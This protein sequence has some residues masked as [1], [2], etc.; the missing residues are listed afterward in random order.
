MTTVADLEA[1]L[2]LQARDTDLD[3][4]RHRRA[5]LPELA[6]LSTIDGQVAELD[7]RLGTARSA[8]DVVAGRQEELERSLAATESRAAAINKRL[9]GGTVSATRDLQAMAAEVEALRARASEFESQAL[10]ALEECEPLDARVSALEGEKASLLL[11]RADAEARLAARQAEIDEEMTAHRDARAEEAARVPSELATTYERLR[12]HLGGTGVARLVGSRCDGCHL[13]LPATALD[14][15]RRGPAG[16]VEYCEQ[17][18]R[19]LV[20]PRA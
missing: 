9:Y 15:L 20:A 1:L 8:R 13:T 10:E 17:C 6:E 2:V 7:R 16:N 5:T 4:C 19:I 12:Q 11:A 14:A 3:R 18:G